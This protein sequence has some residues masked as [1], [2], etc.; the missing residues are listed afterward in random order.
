M[1]KCILAIIMVA[2]EIENGFSNW[3][4]GQGP[5]HKKYLDFGKW[6]EEAAFVATYHSSLGD[7]GAIA[8]ES[9]FT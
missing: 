5:A 1:K 6:V 4:A 3:K 7:V 8:R 2:S 9:R